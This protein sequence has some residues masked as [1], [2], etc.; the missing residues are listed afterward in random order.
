M[1]LG[2]CGPVVGMRVSDGMR[3]VKYEMGHDQD[4]LTNTIV[5]VSVKFIKFKLSQVA[6]ETL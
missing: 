2:H 3:E 5:K 4:K 6:S 1:S